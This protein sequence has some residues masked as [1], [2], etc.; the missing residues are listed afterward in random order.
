MRSIRALPLLLLLPLLLTLAGCGGAVA[1]TTPARPP[2]ASAV[3]AYPGA[4]GPFGVGQDTVT[5]LPRGVTAFPEIR[6]LIGHATGSVEVEMYELQQRDILVDLVAAQ[7][8]GL[9]VTVITDPSVAVSAV[10]AQ[11][12]RADGVDTILYPIR[13]QMIDHV[14]L[15]VVDDGAVAVVGGINWGSSSARNHDMDILVSGPAALNLHRVFE[16]DL[17]TSGRSA[18]IPDEVADSAI[19]VVAT[20]PTPAIR[21][22]VVQ[23]IEDAQTSIDLELYVLTDLGI[24]HALERAQARGVHVRLLLDPRERPSDAPAAELRA[25]AVPVRLYRGGG[26]LLHAKTMVVDAR[27]VVVGSA[28]WSGGGF[29][30][31]HELDVVMPD[32]PAVAHVITQAED[33][34]WAAADGA[35]SGP[36]GGGPAAGG[37]AAAV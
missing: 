21:P 30:R 2:G 8:R 17:V 27:T 18:T 6:R 24:V 20:L 36:A 37:D 9:R 25:R 22:L 34:D 3:P 13:K 31:N 35:S 10:S 33:S 29:A 12:L 32:A 11:L 28:N 15:L 23:A 4:A 16:R 5:V 19:R 1:S 7:H 26:E 14:K